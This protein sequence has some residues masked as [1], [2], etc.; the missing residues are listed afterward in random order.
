MLKWAHPTTRGQTNP[1]TEVF[2]LHT[3]ETMKN[4]IAKSKSYNTVPDRIFE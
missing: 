1:I 4:Y 2:E 3:P